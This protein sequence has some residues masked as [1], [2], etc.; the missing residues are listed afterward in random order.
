MRYRSIGFGMQLVATDYDEPVRILLASEKL[1]K[2]YMAI[3]VNGE[4]LIMNDENVDYYS[5]VRKKG[6]HSV[7]GATVSVILGPLAHASADLAFG[8]DS[9]MKFVFIKLKNGKR[10][11][12]KVDEG[13]MHL[14]RSKNKHSKHDLSDED[15]HWVLQL[16][17]AKGKQIVRRI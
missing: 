10:I 9:R 8:G 7:A 15:K 2:E 4:T 14:I 16:K 17:N 1:V 5:I 11:L 3:E 12:V 6:L 13:Y